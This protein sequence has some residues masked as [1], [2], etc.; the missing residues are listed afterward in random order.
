MSIAVARA[1]SPMRHLDSP[2]PLIG[3]KIALARTYGTEMM[4]RKSDVPR[5]LS[6]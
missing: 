6:A 1:L 2:K 3:D 5:R 4:R